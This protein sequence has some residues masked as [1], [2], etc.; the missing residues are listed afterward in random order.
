MLQLAARYKGG[1]RSPDATQ[2]NKTV[3]LRRVGRSKY[4]YDPTRLSELCG[5]LRV[6]F[7]NA[8]DGFRDFIDD[9]GVR[10]TS[11]LAELDTAIKTLPVTSADAE[12]GFSTMNI[13]CTELRSRLLVPRL[14]NLMFVSLVGPSLEEF[15]PLPYVKQWLLGGHRAACDNQSK[16]CKD[17]SQDDLRYGHMWNVFT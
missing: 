2:L 12:R 14:A 7:G 6:N 1:F 9:G 5:R 3:L 15:E 10:V 4:A 16:K 11:G 8:Q 17:E 13:I